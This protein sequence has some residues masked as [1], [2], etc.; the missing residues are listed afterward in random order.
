MKTMN[1]RQGTSVAPWPWS[2]KP[3][4][5]VPDKYKQLTGYNE[6]DAFCIFDKDGFIA[7]EVVSHWERCV[8]EENIS[9]MAAAPELRYALLNLIRKVCESCRMH[10]RCMREDV[11]PCEKNGDCPI[12][13]HDAIRALNKSYGRGN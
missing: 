9:L 7:S 12:E 3:T 6:S 2:W 4:G 1:K 13:V 8:A 10:A 5:D 11:R